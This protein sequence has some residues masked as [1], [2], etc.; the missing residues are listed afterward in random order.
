MAGVLWEGS[1]D[2]GFTFSK[3]LSKTLRTDLQPLTKFRQLCDIEDGSELGIN[4]GDK[5]YFDVY[6]DVATQGGRLVENVAM[7]ESSFSVSQKSLTVFEAGHSVPYTG[8]LEFLSLHKVADIIDK[9]LKND[10]KKFFDSESYEAMK[11][12]QLRAAPTSGSSATSVTLETNGAMSITNNLAMNLEHVKGIVD[13][14]GE[15]NIPPMVDDDYV[16]ITHPTTVRQFRND[17]EQIYQY[18]SMGAA[19]LFEGEIGRYENVRF[20]KQTNIPKGGANDSTTFDSLNRIADAWNNGLSSW[21]FFMGADTVA[22]GIVCPEEIRAKIPTDFGR[23]KGIA[24]YYLGG[25]ALVH[26][27]APNSRIVMWD[28]AA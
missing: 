12:T 6:S 7:T 22:E 9:T 5:L 26:D 13:T 4:A 25:F 28:S 23:S 19:R 10:A 1:L 3:K 21:V 2:A 24:W 14:M 15:R 8:K 16:A 18:T 20:I 17:L 11:L 27:D